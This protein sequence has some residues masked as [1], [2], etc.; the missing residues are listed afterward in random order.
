MTISEAIAQLNSP[1]SLPPGEAVQCLRENWKDTEPLLLNSLDQTLAN[2]CHLPPILFYYALFLCAEMRSRAAFER[3]IKICRLPTS[4][5]RFLVDDVISSHMYEILA[6]T[7]YGRFDAL[8]AVVE[9]ESLDSFARAAALDALCLLIV[10]EEFPRAA[11]ESYC[12]DLLDFRLEPQLGLIWHVMIF[13]CIKLGM[14]QALPLIEDAYANG[15]VN[16]RVFPFEYM[17]REIGLSD[18]SLGQY[19]DKFRDTTDE[20]M[21]SYLP[22]WTKGAQTPDQVERERVEEL[23]EQLLYDDYLKLLASQT[24]VGRND[25]CPC[26]SGKKFKKCCINSETFAPWEPEEPANYADQLIDCGYASCEQEQNDD[27]FLCWNQAWREIIDTNMIKTNIV[28]PGDPDCELFDC[29]ESFQAWIEAF[30]DLIID[31]DLLPV[32]SLNKAIIT[33]RELLHKFPA[34]SEALRAKAE[35]ALAVVLAKTGQ[36]KQAEALFNQSLNRSTNDAV[37]LMRHAFTTGVNAHALNLHP[38]WE[39]SL[40]YAE[41]AMQL[42]NERAEPSAAVA[43][44]IQ[45]LKS[46][47]E[48]RTLRMEL[49]DSQ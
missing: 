44:Y 29:C 16:D 49:A 37:A 1:N 33:T 14:A 22:Q 13:Q 47:I 32:P 34:M 27:A 30:L 6:R 35:Y 40:A 21:L 23:L 38:N 5:I 8:K 10:T 17:V 12:L 20:A 9:D 26:G 4:V 3:Y 18:G 7:C 24:P 11:L 15:F 48:L 36:S 28:D 43:Q 25:P 46:T 45:Q 42:Q 41:K 31:Y 19:E 39:N 2:P